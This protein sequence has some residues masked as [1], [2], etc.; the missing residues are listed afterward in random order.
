MKCTYWLALFAL[1]TLFAGG[2]QAQ[3]LNQAA[4]AADAPAPAPAAPSDPKMPIAKVGNVTIT[5]DDF[6]RF[7]RFRLRRLSM[8]SGK[9]VEADAKFRSQAMSELIASRILEVLADEAKVTVSDEEVAKDFDTSKKAFKTGDEYSRYLKEQGLDETQ[10]RDEVRRKLKINRF[11]ESNT[12]DIAATPEEVQKMYDDLKAQGKMN[13]DTRTADIAQ[14]VAIFKADDPASEKSAKDK[15][16]A[17][18][19]RIVKGEKFEDVGK[20]ISK[21]LES[22]VQMGIIEEARPSALFPDIAKAISAM[23]AGD[24][25]ETLKTPRGYGLVTVKAWYEPGIVPFEKMKEKL[26]E[27][28]RATKQ[29]EAITALVK[30][31][32]DRVPIEIYKAGPGEAGTTPPPPSAQAP[33]APA[34]SSV[35][36]VDLSNSQ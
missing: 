24:M 6:A 32:R 29:H 33:A 36:P 35:P 16:D 21:D 11:V 17:L 26:G 20:E 34:A 13:R 14:I 28:V 5:A 22:G 15:I 4:A 31:A 1:A 9:Q 12:K 3:G 25:S 27:Q 23:K 19:A 18:R 8:E 2:A 7:A 10:L 30:A